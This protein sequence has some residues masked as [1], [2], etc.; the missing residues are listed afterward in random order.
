MA[1]TPHGRK[2]NKLREKKKTSKQTNKSHP[3]LWAI[4]SVLE[5][6]VLV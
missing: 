2:E 1:Y 3:K 4:T 6:E 5:R